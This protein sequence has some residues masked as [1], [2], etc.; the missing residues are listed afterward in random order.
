MLRPVAFPLFARRDAPLLVW[1]DA[2]E[3]ETLLGEIGAFVWCPVRRM[4]FAAGS[5]APSSLLVWLR[6]QQIKKKYITQWE[7][8]AVLVAFLCF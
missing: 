4:A 3:D 1:T 2:S 8:F 7:L 6:R 5:K